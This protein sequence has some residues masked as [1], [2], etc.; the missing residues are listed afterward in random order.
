MRP[1]VVGRR[2]KARTRHGKMGP[3]KDSKRG[4]IAGARALWERPPSLVHSALIIPAFSHSCYSY[5]IAR[6]GHAATQPASIRNGANRQPA[7]GHFP[8]TREGES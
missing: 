8:R 1:A 2:S 5:A 4:R 6:E 7:V 3:G